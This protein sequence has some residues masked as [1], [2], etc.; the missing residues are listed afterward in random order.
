MV[1][2]V[3]D[4]NWEA[5][6]SLCES[7][8]VEAT[9]VGKFVD[10]GRLVLKYQDTVVG[11]L[12]MEFL[13]EGRPPIIRDAHYEIPEVQPID[14]NGKAGNLEQDLV[15][16]LGSLN[17]ASKEW[18]VRQYDHEVQAG[19]VIKP[20]VG[21]QNDG[22]GDAAVVKPVLGSNRGITVSCGMNPRYGDYDTYHM[23]ASH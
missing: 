15:A 5:F 11:D 22:P 4:E 21:V 6:R 13:H 16:I 19:S 10:H 20:L 8:G 23:A 3:S 9:I 18:V 14:L 2:S 12:T 7:E 1:F 17:V